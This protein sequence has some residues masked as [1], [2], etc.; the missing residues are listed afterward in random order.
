[1]CAGINN[2]FGNLFDEDHSHKEM[3]DVQ[4]LMFALHTNNKVFNE[5]LNSNSKI[6]LMSSIMG[7]QEHNGS[8]ATIYELQSTVNNV[9]VSIS[10]KLKSKQIWYYLFIRLGGRLGGPNV[11]PESASCSIQNFVIKLEN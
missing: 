9:M 7:V 1:M 2:G 8:S 6:I 5:H 11:Y 3:L 4:M 10:E